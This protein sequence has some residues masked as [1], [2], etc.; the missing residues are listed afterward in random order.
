MAAAQR[1]PLNPVDHILLATHESLRRRGYCGLSVVLLADLEGPL[2]SAALRSA[3]RRVGRTFPALSARI[4]FTPIMR[5]AC[6]EVAGDADTE[7]A[8]SYEYHKLCVASEDTLAPISRVMGETIDLTHAPHVRL[9]HVETGKD[10]HRLGLCWAHPLMDLE[11]GHVL[12]RELH[13]VLCGE[14]TKLDPDPR[15]THPRPFKHAFPVS[16]F[17]AWQGRFRHAYYDS[18]RQPR[19]IGRPDVSHKACGFQTR[20]YDADFRRRFES[21]AKER[22]RPGPLRYTRALLIGIA[23]TY[24]AMAEDRGRP[25]DHFLFPQALPVPRPRHR[26]G[27]HG[28]Y[29]TIPWVVFKR[30]EL[31]DWRCADVAALRQFADYSRKSRDAA[32]WEMFRAMQRWPFAVS[33]YLSEHRIPRGAAGFTSYRFDDSVTRI[34]HASITN[35]AGGGPMNCHPGWIVANTTYGDTMTISLTY[36]E[37]YVDPASATEFLDR[38]E[39][40]IGGETQA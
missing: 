7:E 24:L 3:V 22:T 2:D 33:R 13:A 40:E 10:R 20:R 8:I 21:I 14:P 34:G 29:V 39:L 36:F 1:Y 5:R 4:R 19:L 32:T 6:W 37:D 18:F 16:F 27:V 28:N 35:L 12:L 15:A 38:L 30:S 17:R 23:R 11:G 25:R 9:I 26:P 31:H